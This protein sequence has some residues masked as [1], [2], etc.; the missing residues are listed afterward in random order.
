[1]TAT[2]FKRSISIRYQMAINLWS[3]YKSMSVCKCF[4]N[5]PCRAV[6]FALFPPYVCVGV[7]IKKQEDWKNGEKEE[8]NISACVIYS[9]IINNI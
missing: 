4:F 1:M 7:M 3:N 6:P 9:Y 8:E 2:P 5:V